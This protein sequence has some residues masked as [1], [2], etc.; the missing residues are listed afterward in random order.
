MKSDHDSF[1]AY[2]LTEQ[3]EAALKFKEIRNSVQPYEVPDNEEVYILQ[4]L[5]FLLLRVL[6]T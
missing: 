5:L 2:Y 1:L 3:D 4:S 6:F